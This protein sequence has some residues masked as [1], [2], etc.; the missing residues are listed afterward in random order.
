MPQPALENTRLPLRYVKA[1]VGNGSARALGLLEMLGLGHRVGH[2]LAVLTQDVAECVGGVAALG[3]SSLPQS[4][5]CPL[6][7]QARGPDRC[8]AVRCP[9][10]RA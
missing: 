2:P 6:A 9:L 7:T 8:L 5:F 10:R 3:P 1:K 4:A